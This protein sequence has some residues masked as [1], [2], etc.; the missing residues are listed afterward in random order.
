[1]LLLERGLQVVHTAPQVHGVPLVQQ[2]Q[3]HAELAP[4]EHTAVVLQPFHLVHPCLPAFLGHHP[5]GQMEKN[6]APL[7]KRALP[8]PLP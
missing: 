5:L 4:L 3:A 2:T 1:M 8:H 6:Y 7:E